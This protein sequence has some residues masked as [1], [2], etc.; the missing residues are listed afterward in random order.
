[1]LVIGKIVNLAKGEKYYV[2]VLLLT[3]PPCLI[4]FWDRSKLSIGVLWESQWVGPYLEFYLNIHNNCTWQVCLLFESILL[5][6][7]SKV[8]SL[9]FHYAGVMNKAYRFWVTIS[10]KLVLKKSTQK[11]T[12]FTQKSTQ[13]TKVTQ[14]VLKTV[15][16]NRN[17]T[18]KKH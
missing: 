11:S 14:Q 10:L 12:K 7:V 8:S 6:K 17:F 9:W 4:T 5:Q 13:K 16:F 1:M 3:G 18:K 2:Y 15:K